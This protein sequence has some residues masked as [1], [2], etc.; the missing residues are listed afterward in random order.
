[1]LTPTPEAQISF[2]PTSGPFAAASPPIS[3]VDEYSDIAVAVSYAGPPLPLVYLYV[4]GVCIGGPFDL[5]TGTPSFTW[6]VDDY[7]GVLRWELRQQATTIAAAELEVQPRKLSRA[8]VAFIKERRIP[9]LLAQL[10]ARNAIRLRYDDD[11]DRLYHFYSLD[12]SVERLL[13][14]SARLLE[15]PF[16]SPLAERI[17]NRLAYRSEAE[18]L[19]AVGNIRG[20]VLWAATATRW[21]NH[22]ADVGLAHE[23]RREIKDYA[24]PLNLIL[25]ALHR[26]LAQQLRVLANQL[27]QRDPVAPLV[28]TMQAYAHR[29]DAWLERRL[30]APLAT[31]L[32]PTISRQDVAR[33]LTAVANPAYRELLRLW[34][35]FHT[36][37]VSL[38]PAAHLSGLQPMHK[39]YELWCVCEVAAALGLHEAATD[40]GPGAIFSGRYLGQPATLYYDQ[41]VKS[42][43]LSRHRGPGVRPDIVLQL[44]GKRLLLDAKYRVKNED[45]LT[46]DLYKMLGYMNDLRINVGSII[47]PGGVEREPYRDV[48]SGQLVYRLPL[49]PNRADP[50]QL[51]AALRG[52][53]DE[54][55]AAA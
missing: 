46:E 7:V 39:I 3:M 26:T 18:E 8:D 25:V 6:S 44:G 23:C 38:D 48:S 47:Y 19:H 43:W 30:L 36:R 31:A 37:Y 27:A 41:P 33:E 15:P 34:R 13:H 49:R 2:Y 1:M 51:T 52:W 11:S 55:I 12:Y 35:D 17:Y 32:P 10:A 22:R 29:H 42:G 54:M 21:A 53:L 24:T 50:H 9:T 28:A 40:F 5:R 14:F 16:A 20:A 45:A 4:G